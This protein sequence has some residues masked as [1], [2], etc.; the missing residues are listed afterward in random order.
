MKLGSAIRRNFTGRRQHHTKY[1]GFP[2]LKT[3]ETELETCALHVV[4]SN[5]QDFH[6]LYQYLSY[7]RKAITSQD[8]HHLSILL[9]QRSSI[10]SNIL[11]RHKPSL[12]QIQTRVNNILRPARTIRRMIA[13]I[14][15]QNLLLPIRPRLIPL[16]TLMRDLNPTWCHQVHADPKRP[17]TNRH[18][19]HQ[20]QQARFTR[21][22]P[23]LV[24]IRLVRA[25]TANV[26]D[27]RPRSLR[28]VRPYLAVVRARLHIR[29]ARL[30]DRKG[31]AEVRLDIRL[32]LLPRIFIFHR[33]A[34]FPLRSSD[35]AIVDEH[36]DPA[37]EEGLRGR[38]DLGP[39]IMHVA[40]VADG[41]GDF[42][43]VVV[44][45]QVHFR[46]VLQFFR[47]QVED[48]HVMAGFEEHAGHGAADAAGA[49]A[50]D[51]VLGWGLEGHRVDCIV[52]VCLGC[53]GVASRLYGLRAHIQVRT[54]DVISISEKSWG[55]CDNESKISKFGIKLRS[56]GFILSVGVRV[57][58]VLPFPPHW[59]HSLR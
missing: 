5:L 49:A 51:D 19:V 4:F 36:I 20:P 38:V 28:L 57:F 33:L 6:V 15:L 50:D 47:V 42:L 7:E 43:L 17:Q 10:D 39:D 40:Q 23:L 21:R 48:E 54:F 16:L 22:I 59:S 11:P 56:F 44:L 9:L 12:N 35:T 14:L 53:V 52:C 55:F 34:V 32:P 58:A 2:Y 26:N 3:D 27:T 8:T 46:G 18:R 25:E 30:A 29:D 31:A 45:L 13:D 41:G 37:V 1:I 24:R